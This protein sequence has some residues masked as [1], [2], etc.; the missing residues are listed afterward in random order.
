[1]FRFFLFSADEFSRS[2]GFPYRAVDKSPF[3]SYKLTT[4]NS[5]SFTFSNKVLLGRNVQ[6]WV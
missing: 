5:L 2:D 4:S 6:V 3:T 1:M